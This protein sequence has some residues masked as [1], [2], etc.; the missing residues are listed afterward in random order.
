MK[1]IKLYIPK[2]KIGEMIKDS[3]CDI[4]TDDFEMVKCEISEDGEVIYLNVAL[5]SSVKVKVNTND[6]YVLRK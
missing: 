3:L 2:E 1:K 6:N 4:D 5:D